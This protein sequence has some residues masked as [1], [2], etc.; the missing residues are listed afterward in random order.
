M[1]KDD[2]YSKQAMKKKA[3]SLSLVFL[4]ILSFLGQNTLLQAEPEVAGQDKTNAVYNVGVEASQGGKTVGDLSN[5]NLE[6]SFNLKFSFMFKIVNDENIGDYINQGL[7]NEKEQVNEK[8]IANIYLGENIKAA[9]EAKLTTPV[10]EVKSGQKVGVIS[11]FNDDSGKTFAKMEFLSDPKDP[12]G[13][14]DYE[15]EDL[16]QLTVEFEGMFEALRG[17]DNHGTGDKKFIKILEK[18]IELPSQEKVE[19]FTLNKSGA[20]IGMDN[21][22]WTIKA[23]RT[24]DSQKA[25]IAGNKIVDNLSNVGEVVPGSFKINNKAVEDKDIYNSATK[26]IEY[27]FPEGS[28]GEQVITF[29]T[30]IPWGD[31]AKVT[32]ENKVQLVKPEGEPEE[33]I[34]K[35]EPS[36]APQISKTFK[37]VDVNIDNNEKALLWEIRA[38]KAGFSYGPTWISDV[39]L[40]K[41]NAPKPTRV[42]VTVEKLNAEG[43]WEIINLDDS[44]VNAKDKPAPQMKEDDP[45][46]A[47]P[48]KYTK[49]EIYDFGENAFTSKI[50]DDEYAVKSTNWFFLPN[51]NGEIKITFK[52]IFATDAV[53]ESNAIKN[54]AEIYN[55]G[56]YYTPIN[57][58]IFVGLG[59]ISKHAVTSGEYNV[60]GTAPLFR[61]G[62]FP[63]N[64]NVDLSKAFVDENVS[65]YEVFFYDSEEELKANKTKLTLNEEDIAKLPEGTF[66]KLME[67]NVNVNLAYVKDSIKS[68][69]SEDKLKVD[70]YPLMLNGEQVGEVVRVSGF[71]ESKKYEL[72]IQ[73]QIQDFYEKAHGKSHYDTGIMSNTA[74]LAMGKAESLKLLPATDYDRFDANLFRK[75]VLNYDV[76]LNDL[77][78]VWQVKDASYGSI[79]TDYYKKVDPAKTFNYKDRTS[80]FRININPFGTNWEEYLKDVKNKPETLPNYDKV[81]L[82]DNLPDDWKLVPVDDS[83]AMFAVYEAS[84]SELI[85]IEY[86]ISYGGSPGQKRNLRDPQATRRLSDAEIKN[87]LT[88]DE[89]KKEWTF[90]NIDGKS[91]MVVAKAQ[92]DK[93]AFEKLTENMSQPDEAHAYI[94]NAQ[95]QANNELPRNASDNMNVKPELLSKKQPVWKGADAEGTAS[96]EWTIEHKPYLKDY[97]S[98]ELTDVLDENLY[99]PVNEKGQLDLNTIK[100]EYSSELGPDGEYSNYQ[101]SMVTAMNSKDSNTVQAIYDAKTHEL[102]FKLPD[103]K[104]PKNPRA[105]KITYLT[106]LEPLNIDRDTVKNIVKFQSALG[107]SEAQGEWEEQLKDN[108]AWASLK[109][110]PVYVFQKM[111]KADKDSN[112]APLAGATFELYF[113][114]EVVNTKVSRNDGKIIFVNLK[115]GEYELKE[116][117][118]PEG[119][120]IIEKTIKFTIT[121]DGKL[122]L[123]KTN[124]DSVKGE[125]SRLN[126]VLVYNELRPEETTTET[127]ATTGTKP[128][129]PSEGT[130]SSSSTKP[131]T[132]KDLTGTGESINISAIVGLAAIVSAAVLILIAKRREE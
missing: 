121:A 1:R 130:K 129:K 108:K 107:G 19:K 69:N 10:Y 34:A 83:G 63:W 115:P 37:G 93:A 3:L 81:V 14:F 30:K 112:Y 46:P 61:Q 20:Q 45:C 7:E 32:V 49:S 89:A 33:H 5:L 122:E 70:V 82:T 74:I 50:K 22:M 86:S 26:T 85:Q 126:P 39:F 28:E 12:K 113:N 65:V 127:T 104:D 27:T 29:E 4:F 102:K 125:G 43:K 24:V 53:I 67:N 57:P 117:V 90:N 55:C 103:N 17:K 64:I 18:E 51:L 38:G 66:T 101:E 2:F 76:D 131:S 40:G 16:Q 21:I 79:Y 62:I 23:S 111:G 13:Q 99:V 36:K 124:P 68:N 100:V 123:S 11:I 9:D 71:R 80:F 41:E 78:S 106:Y 109:N 98:V 128:S 42:E 94:N 54:T 58:P 15:P 72:E 116:T 119:Y 47:I 52:Q 91:Y 25:D 48:D 60:Y 97:K 73:T 87:L 120:K 77:K 105:W 132:P 88:F 44:F 6:S 8:D 84:P 75:T 95:I 56:I 96:L 31:K 110:Y 35:V 59:S 114:K 92:L 118:A